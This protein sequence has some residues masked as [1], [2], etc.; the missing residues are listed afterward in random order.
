MKIY[1]HQQVKI[2]G[3]PF[4]HY[5]RKEIKNDIIPRKGDSIEDSLWKDPGEYEVI[6]ITLNY[7]E[8]FCYV[9]LCQYKHEIPNNRKDE[10]KKIASSH[11]WTCSWNMYN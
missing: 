5:W 8:D 1:L 3:D 4:P 6:D 10:F 11:G 2:E 9:Y 7:Q